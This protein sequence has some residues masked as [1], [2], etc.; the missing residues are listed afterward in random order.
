MSWGRKSTASSESWIISSK[1]AL[2]SSSK[3]GSRGADLA[4]AI[5]VGALVPKP[6]AERRGEG[7]SAGECDNGVEGFDFEA[8]VEGKGLEGA[9]R[10]EV[11]GLTSDKSWLRVGK[12]GVFIGVWAF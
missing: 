10:G 5:G 8:K 9:P 4:L 2:T 1:D 12:P 6:I 7:W 11:S 3:V